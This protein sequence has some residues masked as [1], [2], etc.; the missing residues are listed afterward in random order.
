MSN[1]NLRQSTDFKIEE[2][3]LVS[4][5]GKYNL[6]GMFE[7]L[8]IY[9]S[10]LTP[11]SSGNILIVDAIGL[12]QKLLFDGTEYLLVNIT[13]GGNLFPIKKKFAIFSQTDRKSINQTSESYIL[14]FVSEELLL[15]EQQRVSQYYDGTYSDAIFSILRDY[16]KV[17]LRTV[18]NS[19]PS[20]GTNQFIVPNLKP[21]D[22]INWCVK[23]SL[24]NTNIPNFMFFENNDGYNLTT[25]SEIMQS[26]P[27][28]N[29]N[30]SAK[31]L[32]GENM[33]EEL[34]GARQ[35]EVIT[36][37]D[38]IKNTQSGVYSGSVIG[39]DAVTRS[40]KKESY[41]FDDL[42]SISK[43]AN[44]N[45]I[46]AKS[47][48]KTGKSNYDMDNSRKLFYL[49]TSD[50]KTNPYVLKNYAAS[51]QAQDNPQRYIFQREAILQNF[52]GQR[53][54]LVLPGNFLVTSGKTL[55]LD[56]PRTAAK[57]NDA[58]NYD[59]TLK[60]KYAILATRHIISYSKFETIV[61]VV[62]DSTEK[63][64]YSA[65]AQQMN[66]LKSGYN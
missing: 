30:F 8:N 41:T 17:P 18:Y 12:T 39:F 24:N 54:K 43:H 13:K 63:P 62:T 53:L 3:F 47:I 11:C 50:R 10:M 29:V 61:E 48:N 52:V 7:E 2:L 56:V 16:L 65:T 22:A 37:Y 58:D 15:S 51:I 57:T 26:E 36:Q 44:P 31:N 60:G 6:Q 23:R 9:D 33:K 4:K 1:F 42:Y 28:F 5:F 25:L 40:F 20:Y 64:S 45:P 46:V 32:P 21:F 34:V 38:F 14:K 59:N 19:N 55:Y 66:I 27:L 49:D 35:M